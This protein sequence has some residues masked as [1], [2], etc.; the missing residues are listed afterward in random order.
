[1][2]LFEHDLPEKRT[3]AVIDV[4]GNLLLTVTLP[5]MSYTYYVG[6]AA[7]DAPEDPIPVPEGKPFGCGMTEEVQLTAGEIRKIDFDAMRNADS[8]GGIL[9]ALGLP[10]DFH[11]FDG[12]KIVLRTDTY[13]RIHKII[14]D[15]Y[16]DTA[17]NIMFALA[18]VGIHTTSEPC[19]PE[20][21]VWLLDGWMK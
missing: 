15:N 5:P 17:A 6:Y 14:S 9:A 19:V 20:D 11:A 16:P 13:E 21:E 8:V 1:M 12:S 2:A 7:D 4:N 3:E 10:G 18:Y